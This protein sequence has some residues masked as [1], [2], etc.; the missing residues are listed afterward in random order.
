MTSDRRRQGRIL[1]GLIVAIAIS[2]VL[3]ACSGATASVAPSVEPTVAPTPTPAPTPSP[4]PID[5]SAAFLEIIGDK[6]FSGAA[7]VTGTLMV[8]TTPG[9]VSG[10]YAGDGDSS[11]STLTV[12]AGSF[13]QVTDKISTGGTRWTR[14]SP[15]PWL[16]DLPTPGGA[17]KSLADTLRGLSPV[18][19]LGVVSHG[20]KQLHHLQPKGGDALTSEQAG[21]DTG[22]ATDGRFS[23]DFYVTEDGTPAVIAL[24]GTWTQGSGDTAVKNAVEIEYTFTAIGKPHTVQPPTDVWVRYTSK[25]NGY[26]MAH[27]A[28]WTVKGA[29]NK[30]RYLLGDQ[31]YIFVTLTRYNRPTDAFVTALKKTY[32][33]DF[34]DPISETPTRLG[35]QPAIRLLYEF[36]NAKKQE[37]T[38]ADDVISREGIGWEVF[39]LT[40]GGQ[41][42]VAVFDQFVATFEF[43]TK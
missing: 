20:G 14:V 24:A 31:P 21:F 15:G 19:D 2:L 9:T 3:G 11:D 42:D 29:K 39:L 17:N 41:D 36:T 32:K 23:M 18:S 30:D 4:T 7:T 16:E 33:A 22:T 25:D 28:D 1:Q 8:G 26:T 37:V 12:S 43:T 10:T 35:G 5:A 27:P 34:G 38:L 40:R 13:K 6:D